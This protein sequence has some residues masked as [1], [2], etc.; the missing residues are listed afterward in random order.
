MDALLKWVGNPAGKDRHEWSEVPCILGLWK[1]SDG[2]SPR[3]LKKHYL[4]P[5]WRMFSEG[6]AADVMVHTKSGQAS[7]LFFLSAFRL[8]E[9]TQS[10]RK[11]AQKTVVSDQESH[12]K[13]ERKV[14]VPWRARCGEGWPP[15]HSL[16]RKSYCASPS[17]FLSQEVERGPCN[18]SS[19]SWRL[20]KAWLFPIQVEGP[21]SGGPNPGSLRK[22]GF[23]TSIYHVFA[24]DA[25]ASAPSASLTY[26]SL[27]LPLMK[28]WVLAGVAVFRVYFIPPPVYM[29]TSPGGQDFSACFWL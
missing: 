12:W 7:N 25:K 26:P 3:L 20:G 24:L 27:S 10:S 22:L 29:A 9:P 13:A 19:R 21:G 5:Y 16:S 28:D 6:N 11:G 18:L 1:E 23:S 15:E 17:A 8:A 2:F 4:S 14:G